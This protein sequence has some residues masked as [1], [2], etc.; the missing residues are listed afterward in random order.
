MYERLRYIKYNAHRQEVG[1]KFPA[2]LP[3]SC[4]QLLSIYLEMKKA[5]FPNGVPLGF[6]HTSA[7]GPCCGLAGQ[8]KQTHK[9]TKNNRTH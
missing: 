9:Q 7:P 3:S 8:H 2:P 4:L 5:A 6:T 1:K